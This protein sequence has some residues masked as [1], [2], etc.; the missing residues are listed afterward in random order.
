M[1][2][3]THCGKQLMDDAIV[4]TNCGCAV[5][6]ASIVSKTNGV[7]DIPNVG[8]NLLGFFIPLV[9]LILYCTLQAQT[10][11]KAN[12]IGLFSLI[13]FIVNFVLILIMYSL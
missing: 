10:P 1:K 11:K 5:N 4:C 8:L 9:G 2:Y 3:C 13:G 7:M 12:Q 6:G